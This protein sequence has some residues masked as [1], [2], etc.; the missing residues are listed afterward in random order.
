ML[1]SKTCTEDGDGEIIEGNF[2][3]VKVEGKSRKVRYIEQMDHTVDGDEFE[4]TFLKKVP[5]T[6]E[7]VPMFII[8]KT[9]NAAFPKLHALGMG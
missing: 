6:V 1:G 7:H 3:V 8:N 4:A 9:D 2:V 5:Q